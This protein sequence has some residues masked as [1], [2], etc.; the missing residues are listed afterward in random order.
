MHTDKPVRY[1][2]LRWFKNDAYMDHYTRP[3]EKG[4]VTI[5]LVH[6]DDGSVSW[7]A[8]WC[9]IH[10]RYRRDTGRYIALKELRSSPHTWT[11]N[12][13]TRCKS[14]KLAYLLEII[15]WS[16]PIETWYDD[17]P[18]DCHLGMVK[19]GFVTES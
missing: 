6:N 3:L 5:A 7:G 16:T 14:A 13:W 8:A 4:G 17:W 12:D 15:L 18:E 19:F 2:H 1:Y 10:D 9:S 11:P